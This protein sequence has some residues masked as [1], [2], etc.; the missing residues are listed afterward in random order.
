MYPLTTLKPRDIPIFAEGGLKGIASQHKRNKCH[1][2]RHPNRFLFT[3]VVAIVR[4]FILGMGE[5]YDL[6]LSKRW[7]KRVR[8]IEGHG[9]ATLTIEGKVKTKRSVTGTEVEPLDVELVDGPS[10]EE[11]ENELFTTLAAGYTIHFIRT[12]K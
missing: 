12:G 6:L 2:L 4:A 3:G 7:M 9:N 11:S 10:V 1:S 5:I 8:A